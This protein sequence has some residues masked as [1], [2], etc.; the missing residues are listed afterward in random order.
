MKRICSGIAAAVLALASLA[1]GAQAWPTKPVKIVVPFAAGGATDV[2]ARLL[3]QKLTDAWGQNVIVENRAGAGGN[4]GADVV[5]K[6]PADGYTLLMTSGSIVTANQ[7]MY[8]SLTYDPARDLVAIT[9]VA[10]GPQVIAV[11]SDMPARDLREFIAYA[12]ANPRKVNFGSAGVGT[13]TH[14]AAENFAYSAGVDLT[15]VP[16]KGESA[17]LTDLIGGQ[18]QMVTPNLGGAIGHIQQGKLRALAVTSPQRSPQ[19]PDVPAA[20][21]VIPG[22]ENAGWF[23]L[24][25]PAGTPR[26]VIERIQRDSAKILLADE[27]KAALAKQGMVPVANTPSDFAAAIREESGRWAKVIK[28]RGLAQN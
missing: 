12:K 1:A 18:I 4:I 8:K 2:V 15:H 28:E 21:E 23:G 16:Y 17:A 19:L 24:M 25:A 22:F 6:S 20:A 5:A 14:L 3:A 11:S 10:T 13:Q 26:E 7:H 9:N 27:F